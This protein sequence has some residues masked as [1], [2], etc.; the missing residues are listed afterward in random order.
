MNLLR[1]RNDIAKAQQYFDFVEGHPTNSGGIMVLV[2]L[3]TIHRYYTLTVTFP[4]AYPNSM[5]EV[6]VRKPKLKASPHRYSADQICYMHPRMWNPGRHDL[7]FVI[8]H[9]AK[10][11]SKYEIYRTRGRWPGAGID[12]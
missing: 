6:F 11:L 3:Q 12:H 4:D 10:W 9:A 5:P 7:T 1:I 2:A 8:Q